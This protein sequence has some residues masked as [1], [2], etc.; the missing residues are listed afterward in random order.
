VKHLLVSHHGAYEFGSPKLPQTVEAVILHSLDD[1]DGQD[2]RI[3]FG[4]VSMIESSNGC[5]LRFFRFIDPLPGD[6]VSRQ[7]TSN[8]RS[9]FRANFTSRQF[10]LTA[11]FAGNCRDKKLRHRHGEYRPFRARLLCRK[12]NRLICRQDHPVNEE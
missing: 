2:R 3:A 10:L 6:K 8:S 5:A 1:L 11:I 7:R 12:L 4:T 9:G